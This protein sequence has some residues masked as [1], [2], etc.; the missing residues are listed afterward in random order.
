MNYVLIT[1]ARNEEAFIELTIQ[2]VV[3]QH[4]RPLRWV[5]VSD[6]S[7][8]RTDEIIRKYAREHDW[9]EYVRTAEREERNFAGKAACFNTAYERIRHLD[10]ELVGNIDADLSFGPDYYSFL[11]SKFQLFPKLGL[12]GTPFSEGG[13]TY[14]YRF[15]STDH[16][17]GASQLFRR[18]CFEEIGGYMPVKGGGIDVIAV[19]SSRMRGWCTRTFTERVCHHHRP[20]NSANYRSRFMANV[21]L[22]Q[23]AYR[24]GFHPVW[25]I[26]RSVYQMT[27]K[28]YVIGGIAL[29]VGFFW[30]WLCRSERPISHELVAFQQREQMRRLRAFFKRLVGVRER[31][32]S[33]NASCDSPARLEES[34]GRAAVLPAGPAAVGRGRQPIAK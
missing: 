33:A 22:G 1:A 5:I 26:F 7:T 19:L 25:Q 24:M 23:R 28:P 2:S 31:S 13:E 18:Q 21:K 27:R 20:M 30:C 14:D 34:L 8:D 11:L 17:S 9:I 4:V 6:G 10:F 15:S 16:V 32:P 29:S 3:A 12:A